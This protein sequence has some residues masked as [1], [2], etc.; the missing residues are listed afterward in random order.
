MQR[1]GGSGKGRMHVCTAR[2]RRSARS[3]SSGA[4]FGQ[5]YFANIL[6]ANV[7]SWVIHSEVGASS[8]DVAPR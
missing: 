5:W 4:R 2:G 7:E 1:S 3:G 8:A 6:H